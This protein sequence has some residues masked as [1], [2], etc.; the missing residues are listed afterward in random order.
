MPLRRPLHIYAHPG[1]PAGCRR[2]HRAIHTNIGVSPCWHFRIAD[3]TQLCP[4]PRWSRSYSSMLSPPLLSAY[5]RRVQ[6]HISVKPRPRTGWRER[7]LSVHSVHSFALKSIRRS[8]SKHQPFLILTVD[9][10]SRAFTRSREQNLFS[11]LIRSSKNR[12]TS[13]KLHQG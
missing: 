12:S 7:R 13:K 4:F 6:H 9:Q 10:A 11:P 1:G 3:Y 5:Q 8:K 2:Y